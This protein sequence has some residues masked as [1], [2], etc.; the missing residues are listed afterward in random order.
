MLKQ[1]NELNYK[2]IAELRFVVTLD[3]NNSLTSLKN[4]YIL[5][6]HFKKKRKNLGKSNFSPKQAMS[7]ILV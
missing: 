3:M 6:I 7:K 1:K 5:K 2:D 4:I